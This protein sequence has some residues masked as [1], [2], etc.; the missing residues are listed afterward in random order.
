VTINTSKRG[1]RHPVRGVLLDVNE[2]LFSL[3][4]LEDAF[5][6]CGIDPAL[7]PLWFAHILRDGFALAT[8]GDF[9]RFADIA[10]S[11]LIALDPGRLGAVEARAVLECFHTLEPFADVAPGLQIMRTAGIRVMTLTVGD[12]AL[13]EALFTRAGLCHMVDGFLSADTVR[14]WKPAP[15]PYAYGVAQIGWPPANVAMITAHNWDIH[16]ARRAGLQTGYIARNCTASPL[17]GA[18]NVSGDD[19]PT[20]VERLL[21]QK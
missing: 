10:K 9:Q 1:Q 5:H 4:G 2:T 21:S 11:N 16:G 15:E 8:A 12:S 7:V 20:V 17:F 18:A 19:L 6:A 3:A 13:S 14:R